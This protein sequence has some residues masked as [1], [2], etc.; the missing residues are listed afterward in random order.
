MTIRRH[1]WKISNGDI[2]ATGLP[3]H[4]MFA[5]SVG[6][7][8]SA[9]RMALFLV[10]SNQDGGDRH[11][12]GKFRMAISP[13]RVIRSTSCLFLGGFLGSMNWVALF[14]V[15][16]NQD[17]GRSPSWTGRHLGN[18]RMNRPY[19]TGMNY[20]IHFHEMES[21]YEGVRERIIREE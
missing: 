9:D 6:F 15:R 13:Q 14:L 8:R 1:M 16:L 5:S 10:W 4:F 21:S 3:I 18:F 12:L 19:I 11:L 7:S 20:S 17:G 2:C